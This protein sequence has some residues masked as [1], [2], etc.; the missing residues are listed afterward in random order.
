MR[1][2]GIDTGRDVPAI[3]QRAFT[4]SMS[5]HASG[6]EGAAGPAPTGVWLG[7]LLDGPAEAIV[8]GVQIRHALS[9]AYAAGS[10]V[11]V[12]TMIPWTLIAGLCLSNFPEAMA[13][14]MT[15]YQYGW[16]KRRV[17]LMWLA[18]TG[19]ISFGSGFGY[20]LASLLSHTAIVAVEGF[21]S[22]GML[23]MIIGSMIPEAAH[24]CGPNTT[25]MWLLAG[26]TAAYLFELLESN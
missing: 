19:I 21:A 17:V 6:A 10:N 8:I 5:W 4:H 3:S 9:A 25:G 14:S 26:F 2:G 13:A 12:G 18:L 1:S 16:S 11:S 15:M 20:L 22:G 7:N 24:L 23:V